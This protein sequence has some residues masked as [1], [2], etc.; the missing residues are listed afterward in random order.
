MTL[1][2]LHGRVPSILIFES[3][4]LILEAMCTKGKA[5]GVKGDQPEQAASRSLRP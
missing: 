2:H 1:V 4:I 3:S 5:G